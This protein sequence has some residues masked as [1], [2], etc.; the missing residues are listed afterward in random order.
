[1]SLKQ[2][3]LPCPLGTLLFQGH[4][5]MANGLSAVTLC[6][7]RKE[8]THNVTKSGLCAVWSQLTHSQGQVWFNGVFIGPRAQGKTLFAQHEKELAFSQDKDATHCLTLPSAHL[9]LEG[10]QRLPSYTALHHHNLTLEG[11]NIL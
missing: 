9:P 3:L 6:I 8:Q 5:S 10:H 7:A 4:P 1:M 2:V 11:F